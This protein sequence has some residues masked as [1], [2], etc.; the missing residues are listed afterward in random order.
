VGLRPRASRNKQCQESTL[1]K[2]LDELAD[3]LST[4]VSCFP[5]S[6]GKRTSFMNGKQGLRSLY[7]IQTFDFRL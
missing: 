6:S 5:S 2:A 4:F 1:V 3:A 7:H